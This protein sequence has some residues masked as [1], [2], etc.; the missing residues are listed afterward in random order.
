MTQIKIVRN[1]TKATDNVSMPLENLL[2]YQLRRASNAMQAHLRTRYDALGFR[3]I[4][5]SV[6]FMIEANPGITQSQIGHAIE[7]KSANM[8]P[9][10]AFLEKNNHIERQRL[11]GRS[12]GLFLTSLGES[13][14]K[15]LWQCVDENEKW[16]AAKLPDL[17]SIA[18]N[19][20][21]KK[22]WSDNS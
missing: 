6:L 9:I 7:V 2:G 1:K 14:A 20:R 18:I 11:D 19:E 13:T 17:D 15:Q 5:A 22:I 4:E 16:L 3:I 8:A 12:Q 21:L 10:I